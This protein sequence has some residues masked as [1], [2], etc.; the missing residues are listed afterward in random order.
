MDDFQKIDRQKKNQ[1]LKLVTNSFYKELVN[2]G[3]NS[4]DIVTVSVNLLD[5]VT[6]HN[7]N[8]KEDV[9]YSNIFSCQTVEN[10]WAES[11]TLKFQDISLQPIR[12]EQVRQVSEWLKN[13]ELSQTFIGFFPKNSE[14]LVNYMCY[15][16]N[17]SYFGVFLEP[18]E[19]IG[20]IGA[21]N[22][23]HLSFKLEMKKL[24]GNP[25]YRNRGLGKV[26]T[27]LF[28]YYVFMIGGFNK[29]YIYS[30]DTN[31]ANIN[32]NSKFGFDLEGILYRDVFVRDEFRDVLRMGL[33]KQN[34]LEIFS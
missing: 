29:V 5:Y 15:N 26:S 8:S 6:G 1:L 11:Q 24:I 13:D 19:L 10:H 3:V 28:L 17:R 31:I 30:L 22:V 23:D 14:E 12:P 4:G 33:L 21:D 2:Y 7:K 16:E 20:F 32:I 9:Y 34:W 25:A 18:G 27:F